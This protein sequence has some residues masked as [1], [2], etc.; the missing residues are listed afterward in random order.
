MNVKHF[1]VELLA[2]SFYLP[3]GSTGLIVLYE[4]YAEQ[5]ANRHKTTVTITQIVWK[6][7]RIISWIFF[8]DTVLIFC[9]TGV[10]SSILNHFETL[11]T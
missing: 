7:I 5:W 10:G 9:A 11:S 3:Y 1:L 4:D 2:Y 6:T 8:F